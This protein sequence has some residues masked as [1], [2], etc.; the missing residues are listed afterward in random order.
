MEELVRLGE[1]LTTN[2]TV[3]GTTLVTPRLSIPTTAITDDFARTLYKIR[4][5][6]GEMRRMCG[7]LGGSTDSH[8]LRAKL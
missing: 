2:Q 6:L 8:D 4:A 3:A 1:E 5:N 7:K